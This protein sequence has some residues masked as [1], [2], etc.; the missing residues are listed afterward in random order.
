MTTKPF[1]HIMGC[2]QLEK[3]PCSSP[4]TMFS[5]GPGEHWWSGWPGAFCMKCHAED[6]DELCVGA[7]CQCPCHEEFWREYAKA[8]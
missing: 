4:E 6:K 1:D 7:V 2:Y 3:R 8:H 5:A